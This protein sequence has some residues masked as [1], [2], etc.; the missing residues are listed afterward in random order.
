MLRGRRAAAEAL[1]VSERGRIDDDRGSAVVLRCGPVS[2]AARAIRNK[3]KKCIL[4]CVQWLLVG[5]WIV[6]IVS[7]ESTAAPVLS[8]FFFLRKAA[9]KLPR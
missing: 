4:F 5:L 7:G 9:K 8:F 1:Y 3:S 6:I 2:G